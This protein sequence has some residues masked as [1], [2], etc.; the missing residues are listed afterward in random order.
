ML[1]ALSMLTFVCSASSLEDAKITFAVKGYYGQYGVASTLT[2]HTYISSSG[3]IYTDNSQSV[4]ASDY[5]D[6]KG[7]NYIFIFRTSDYSKNYIR[8]ACFYDDDYNVVSGGFDGALSGSSSVARVMYLAVPEGASYVRYSQNY[9]SS[10]RLVRTYDNPSGTNYV[11]SEINDVS[12]TD[13]GSIIIPYQ[14]EAFQAIYVDFQFYDYKY[15]ASYLQFRTEVSYYGYSGAGFSG[16]YEFSSPQ[17]IVFYYIDSEGFRINSVSD[18][19]SSTENPHNWVLD[20]DGERNFSGFTLCLPISSVS[21]SI[22]IRLSDFSI[23][24]EDTSAKLIVN[25]TL[26]DLNNLSNDL[27]VPLPS[28]NPNDVINNALSGVD[29]QS[30]INFFTIF[31][32]N[33]LIPL[34]LLIA[35]SFALLGYIFF[36]KR[37]EG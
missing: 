24:G 16:L 1:L 35:V 36:G 17:S 20:L 27:S 26:D 2:A 37:G 23:D 28:I 11:F 29:M 7:Y 4:W 32:D 8:F 22:Q 18:D 34:M 12:I 10:V 15:L 14:T 13:S 5:V 21:S 31:Y 30:G 25:K 9:S 3:Q 19:F 6:V 33:K